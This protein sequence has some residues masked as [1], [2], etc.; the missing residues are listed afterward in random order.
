MDKDE[1]KV[2]ELTDEEL[3]KVNGG[4]DEYV[5]VFLTPKPGKV[6]SV[7]GEILQCQRQGNW[8]QIAN[9]V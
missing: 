4:N 9:L 7:D 1:L 6:D 2:K 5:A 8:T 3:E